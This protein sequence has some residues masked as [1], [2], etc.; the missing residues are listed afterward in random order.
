M[1]VGTHF[2]MRYSTTSADPFLQARNSGA[3][4]LWTPLTY[5]GR[6]CVGILVDIMCRYWRLEVSSH[7]ILPLEVFKLLDT[8]TQ[9]VGEPGIVIIII[10]IIIIIIIITIIIMTIITWSWGWPA[11]TP[12]AAQ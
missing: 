6:R 9:V 4:P 12:A 3:Q 8:A 10:T 1:V 7:H 11:G 2:E 5:T